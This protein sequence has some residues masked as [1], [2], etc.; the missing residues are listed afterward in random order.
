[1]DQPTLEPQTPMSQV[2]A[3]YPG[4]QRALFRGYHI[5]GC[6][7]CGFQPGETLED[8]CRRNEIT[9][10]AAVIT[11][12]RQSDQ[13]D[14]EMQIGPRELADA[15]RGEPKPRLLDIR[16]REEWDAVR[17]QGATR[18][19]QDSMKE[20]L[21][22]WPRE[23]LVVIYDHLGQQSLDA[24]AYFMGQGFRQVRCLKGGIDAWAQD[25]DPNLPRYRLE[26]TPSHG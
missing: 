20:I 25:V 16:T 21:T 26:P 15:L 2:L 18:M 1:M 24:A 3:L 13:Q 22:Q 5:G 7:H 11:H 17:I 10:V 9:D 6:S 19:S 4:A 8:V 12:I 14:Q 23:E